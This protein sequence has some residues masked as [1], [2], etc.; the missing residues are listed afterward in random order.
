[1]HLDPGPC[2][3]IAE[4]G[5]AASRH[6]R[7]AIRTGP[8]ERLVTDESGVVIGIVAERGG[9]TVR[10]RARRGVL[11]ATGA[12]NVK[13]LTRILGQSQP[14]LSRHLKLLA[15]AFGVTLVGLGLDVKYDE[16]SGGEFGVTVAQEAY[17]CLGARSF[18]DAFA[19]SGYKGKP[20]RGGPATGIK[21]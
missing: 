17:I 3:L 13:D 6:S 18:N 12:L 11:L 21:S 14:R 1:M 2:D 16:A 15:E 7:I 19:H 4:L 20:L 10:I 5:R 8:A 9:R